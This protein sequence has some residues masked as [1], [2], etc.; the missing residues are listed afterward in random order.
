[1]LASQKKIILSLV[2]FLCFSL[3]NVLGVF[4]S[5]DHYVY[6][7]ALRLHHQIQW[8]RFWYYLS[9]L[10]SG[11]IIIPLVGILVLLY[12]YRVQRM[13]V[14]FV[15]LLVLVFSINLVLKVFFEIKRPL[16]FLTDYQLNFYSYPSG[17]SLQAV[18][19]FC[20]L[21]LFV[22]QRLF[23]FKGHLIT[24]LGVIMTI[25][26]GSSRVFL[27]VHWLSDVIGG[28]LHGIF[29]IYVLD[30]LLP[31]KRIHTFLKS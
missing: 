8:T 15:L 7:E 3:A 25:L 30:N 10:G 2:V 26:I 21:P 12:L 4:H 17:H 28:I 23:D 11:Y 24:F 27:G 29:W 22:K 16:G 6:N 20:F 31:K 14:G 1:M 9:F 5:L 19:G 13:S 18:L